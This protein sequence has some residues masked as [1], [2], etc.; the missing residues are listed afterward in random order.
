MGRRRSGVRTRCND[1]GDA[2]ILGVQVATG[3][4]DATGNYTLIT[5]PGGTISKSDLKKFA[6][7]VP[8]KYS[9]TFHLWALKD[10]TPWSAAENPG[11]GL[12]KMGAEEKLPSKFGNPQKMLNPVEVKKEGEN[13]FAFEL[14]TK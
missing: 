9:A 6:G 3:V 14:K 10:G 5:L 4:T 8:G 12:V 2:T 11:K 7:A 13:N 1:P